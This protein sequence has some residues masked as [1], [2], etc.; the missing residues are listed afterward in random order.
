MFL[1]S[2]ADNITVTKSILRKGNTMPSASEPEKFIDIALS[3]KVCNSSQN[4]AG[5]ND[6]NFNI[7][8]H[9]IRQS[10]IN[11]EFFSDIHKI[12]KIK[13][14]INLPVLLAVFYNHPLGNSKELLEIHSIGIFDKE[15]GID[16]NINDYQASNED[17]M[18]NLLEVLEVFNEGLQEFTIYSDI[19]NKASG[20]LIDIIYYS[21]NRLIMSLKLKQLVN[22]KKLRNIA[23]N[24][25]KSLAFE[26]SS[27][28]SLKNIYCY[29]SFKFRELDFAINSYGN[30]HLG[31]LK[32]INNPGP[33]IDIEKIH[34]SNGYYHPS[35]SISFTNINKLKDF[36]LYVEL[37]KKLA[38]QNKTI[39]E[40]LFRSQHETREIDHTFKV[41]KAF[42]DSFLRLKHPECGD[43]DEIASKCPDINDHLI[44]SDYMDFLLTLYDEFNSMLN[45]TVA[46]PYACSSENFKILIDS[47][48][49]LSKYGVKY[50]NTKIYNA[51]EKAL[52]KIKQEK[53]YCTTTTTNN[54]KYVVLSLQAGHSDHIYD[55]VTYLSLI[56]NKILV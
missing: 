48:A 1:G 22:A 39:E 37:I 40:F 56:N 52:F 24:K 8:Q 28:A 44:L 47:A 19:N 10:P 25:Q 26:A 21:T 13:E 42:F 4:D 14:F 9:A 55:S 31:S 32:M 23:K 20:D 35:E 12:Q 29:E 11:V 27:F 33:R 54:N 30:V 46:L 51:Y 5:N 16:K 7:N 50:L 2:K 38:E 49:E 17:R 15:Y 3:L 18:N 43:M 53:I 6:I 45:F 41:Q 36:N 34:S